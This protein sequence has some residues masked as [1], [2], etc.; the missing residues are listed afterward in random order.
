MADITASQVKELRE[1]TGAG[2][3]ECKKAL[4]ETGGDLD[5][6]IDL[7][8]TRGLAAIAKKAGRATNEGL[9]VAYVSETGKVGALLEVNC[10]TDFVA[11]NEKFAELAATLV[12]TVAMSAP[13]GVDALKAAQA[14]D[15]DLDIEG[16]LSEAVNVLGENIQVSRFTRREVGEVGALASYIHGGGRIGVL[17]EL[18]ATGIDTD[19][20]VFAALGRDVAMQVAAAAPLFCTREDADPAEVEHEMSI[21]RQQ[22]AESGKPEAIQQKMAE[23]RLEKYFKECT[24][25]E[26]EFIKDPDSTVQAHV[27]TVAKE[28]GGQITVV[29]FDRYVVGEGA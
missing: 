2:M 12:K 25:V 8:R 16:V 13:A 15:S 19:S 28:L 5:A 14:A 7:L 4:V 23:G 6:S 24:L 27:D 26:Q 18:E 3:M 9:V 10:E 21:Y 1:C 11:R 17:V 29:G 22:A 20:E